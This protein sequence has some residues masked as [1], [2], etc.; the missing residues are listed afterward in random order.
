MSYPYLNLV[1]EALDNFRRSLGVGDLLWMWI[2]FFVV[3]GVVVL[4]LTMMVAYTVLAERK[5][6]G[7]VQERPGPNRVG[8]WGLLQPIAD[9]TKLIFKEDITH[10]AA[11]RPV[12][13]FAPYLAFMGPV[14]VL[15]VLP[16]GPGFYYGSYTCGVLFAFA[17]SGLTV[18]GILAGGY[19]SNNKFSLMG[20]VR[21]ASQLMAYEVPFITTVLAVILIAGSFDLVKI[22]EQQSH[23]LWMVAVQPV[24]FLL[25]L[26][27]MVAETNRTPFDIPEGE[28]EIT[29]G[30]H[31][32]YS[33]IRFGIFFLGEYTA[34]LVLAGLGAV[35]YLG[36]WTGPPPFKDIVASP[37]SYTN[38]F[39]LVVVGVLAFTL[40]KA[41]AAARSE[42]GFLWLAAIA[43][44]GL[45]LIGLHVLATAAGL[46]FLKLPLVWFLVKVAFLV[47]LAMLFRWTYLRLRVDQLTSFAWK[48]LFPLALANLVVTSIVVLLMEG[49][50]K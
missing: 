15:L 40:V 1:P 26:V 2:V 22:V 5:I 31:T 36:G 50:S 19:A 28:S 4:A 47:F 13:K 49:G 3:T 34:L 43:L 24:G 8:P 21:A 38:L 32:E 37:F 29:G 30:F 25:F 44:A 16:F 39:W 18:L 6:A 27:C 48:F 7:F 17:L 45:G 42:R 10:D 14:L 9:V 23:G 12:F 20:G 11:D 35:L 46:P 41:L 33:G